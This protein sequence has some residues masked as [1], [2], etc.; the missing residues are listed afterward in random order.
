ML[1]DSG[2]SSRGSGSKRRTTL[3]IKERLSHNLIDLLQGMVFRGV[4]RPLDTL[5]DDSGHARSPKVLLGVVLSVATFMRVPVGMAMSSG[6][7]S[8]AMSGRQVIGLG[9]LRVIG[10]VRSTELPE[11]GDQR[12]GNMLEELHLG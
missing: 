1:R 9:M 6:A 3:G 5:D 4:D 7:T 12:N 2:N 11:H 8:I 10:R